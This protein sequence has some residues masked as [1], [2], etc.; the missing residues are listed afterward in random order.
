MGRLGRYELGTLLGR[1]ASGDVYA[2]DILGP[3]GFRKPVALK[4][5]RGVAPGGE[6]RL[7]GAS[8]ARIVSI[9]GFPPAPSRKG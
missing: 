6:A 4:V 1:G 5:L 9:N 7:G 2:A 8:E 3:A